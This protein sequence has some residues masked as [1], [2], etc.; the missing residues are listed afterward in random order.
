[1][2]TWLSYDLTIAAC[3]WISAKEIKV[4]EIPRMK[5]LAT[6]VLCYLE[7]VL[8]LSFFDIQIHLLVHLVEEIE[9]CG[10]VHARWM[11]WLERYMCTL[12]NNVRQRAYPE[13]SIVEGYMASEAM[14]Y[15]SHILKQLDLDYPSH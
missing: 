6:E 7:K 10:P 12:K 8:P 11:H 3:R 14:F 5:V 13:G 2:Y 9:L 4:S 15:C 1:M